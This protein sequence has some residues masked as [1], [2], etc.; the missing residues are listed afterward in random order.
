MHFA[1]QAYVEETLSSQRYNYLLDTL[2]QV[3][4]VQ[5]KAVILTEK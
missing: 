4:C 1:A 3:T 2:S 5:L